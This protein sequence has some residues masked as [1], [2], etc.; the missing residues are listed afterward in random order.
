VTTTTIL[1]KIKTTLTHGPI[2][3]SLNRAFV[4]APANK[5]A[6]DAPPPDKK[7]TAHPH[8]YQQVQQAAG[9]D[10]QATGG[11]RAPDV[12][13]YLQ[14]YNP[15]SKPS[16]SRW[17]ETLE[18]IFKNSPRSV[19]LEKFNHI[20]KV[21]QLIGY[22]DKEKGKATI[23]HA[24]AGILGATNIPAPTLVADGE[25]RQ[26][27][28]GHYLTGS[29]KEMDARADDLQKQIEAAEALIN[30]SKEELK[31]IK[32]RRSNIEKTVEAE[33]RHIAE[34]LSYLEVPPPEKTA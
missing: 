14:S 2:Q 15:P 4:S 12:P 27:I 7:G 33:T 34:L 9:G 31:V 1:D 11:D 21:E 29:Y 5:P 25:L 10:R 32:T 17:T 30:T 13:T 24:L 23:T 18:V 19:N 22:L 20:Y 3:E 26:E 16:G 6:P 28:L 8:T